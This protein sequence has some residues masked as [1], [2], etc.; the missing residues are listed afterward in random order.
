[1]PATKPKALL[2]VVRVIW[3]TDNG[4][5]VEVGPDP[6]A[7][8]SVMIRDRNPD[9]EIVNSI[10]ITPEQAELLSVALTATAGEVCKSASIAEVFKQAA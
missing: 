9:G 3:N 1:M 5:S 7:E 6:D 10:R 4:S 2:E 8:G